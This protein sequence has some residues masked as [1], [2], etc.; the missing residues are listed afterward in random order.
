[1]TSVTRREIAALGAI[2]IAAGA[3]RIVTAGYSLWFD[4]LASLVFAHQPIGRLWSGWMIRESNPPLYYSLLRVWIGA[5]GESDRVVRLL[6]I[7]IGL[8]GIVAG[9]ALARRLGGATAGLIA[10]ALLSFSASHVAFS[11]EARS[12]VLAH[13]AT[14]VALLGTADILDHRRRGL[15]VYAVATLV[16]LYSH[17]T[18]IVFALLTAVTVAVL[19]RQ[20]PRAFAEWLA[21][22]VVIA[23]GWAWWASIS[24]SQMVAPHTNF[25]WIKQP[26][27]RDAVDQ[28][29]IAYLPTFLAEIWPAGAVLLTGLAMVVAFV[30]RRDRRPIVVLL[31]VLVFVGP[32]TLFALSQIKPIFLYRTIYWA[33]GPVTVLVALF[34][35]GLAPSPARRRILIALLATEALFMAAW[36]AFWQLEEWPSALDAIASVDPHAVVLVEGDAMALAAAHYRPAASNLRIVELRPR[37]AQFD[38]WAQGLYHGTHVDAAGAAALLKA[39]GRVFS[40]T[41]HGHDPSWALRA[42]GLDQPWTIA[43]HGRKP[44]VWVWRARS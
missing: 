42:V 36:L 10:A 41:R 35:A 32:M 19:L 33:N 16:A 27:I 40:L 17:T 25:D 18:M 4:E 1:L 22:N 2:L 31:A 28:T 44:L 8:G 30:V 13:G 20:F 37:S 29:A 23:I 6:S 38:S 9:W 15:L 3:I 26:S 21:T 12:Y 5:F 14:L 39:R 43:S 7:L 11:Q 24:L 34:V